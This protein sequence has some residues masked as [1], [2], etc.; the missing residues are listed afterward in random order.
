MRLILDISLDLFFFK[1]ADSNS[2]GTGDIFSTGAITVIE[3]FDLFVGNLSQSNSLNN[4]RFEIS[5]PDE[6]CLKL[7]LPH[8]AQTPFSLNPTCFQ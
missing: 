4:L 2:L 5:N 6:D 1:L 3:V 8:E 7:L